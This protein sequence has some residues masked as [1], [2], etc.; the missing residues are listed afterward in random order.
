[1]KGTHDFS[2]NCVQVAECEGG[3][4]WIGYLL[5]AIGMVAAVVFFA[6]CGALGALLLSRAVHDAIAAGWSWATLFASLR[7][8]LGPA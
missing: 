1:M 8:R 4:P 6:V 3:E 7:E 5:T 2:A